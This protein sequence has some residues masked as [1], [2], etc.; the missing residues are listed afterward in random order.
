M[1]KFI[2]IF[3][4]IGLVFLSSCEKHSYVSFGFKSEITKNSTGLDVFHVSSYV[5]NI[6]M[7]GS[8]QLSEG[9][10]V[11]KLID[12][13][14]EFVHLDTVKAPESFNVN[15]YYNSKSGY[16]KLEYESIDA[17]GEIDLHVIL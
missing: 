6:Y 2:F 9:S 16:W 12:P 17:V 5:D 14:G 7:V 8:V 13:N 11:V 10:V 1:K 3:I 15:R 4:V